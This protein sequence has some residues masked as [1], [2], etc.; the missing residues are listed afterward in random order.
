[1]LWLCTLGKEGCDIPTSW[2]VSIIALWAL[3]L[4]ETVLLLLL[5]RGLG[6]LRERIKVSGNQEQPFANRGLALGT[7]APP[8]VVQNHEGYAVKLEDLQGRWRIL[9][10]V[11]PG[12]PACESTIE[13]LNA[14]IQERTD[15]EVLVVG[16]VDR[17]S[18]RTLATERNAKMPILTPPPNLAK[19]IYLVQGIPFVYILDEKGIIC[20][21]GVVNAPE[22]L[23]QL[24]ISANAPV[25]IPQTR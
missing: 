23:Q 24:L 14:F 3:V 6:E 15:L 13:T 17:L 19:D 4:F 18:N 8:F 1:M 10:F 16:G 21:K 12:C 22:H 25:V 20:A 11:S 7:Q 2:M 5:L 9:A